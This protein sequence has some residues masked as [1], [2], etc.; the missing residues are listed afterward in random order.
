MK[1]KKILVP[2]K[3][4][5]VDSKAFLQILSEEKSNIKSSRFIPP[6]FGDRG[7]G[8]FEIEYKF[9]KLKEVNA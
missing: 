3:K 2:V 7:F 5:T 6:M 4:E 8:K 9:S 1:N